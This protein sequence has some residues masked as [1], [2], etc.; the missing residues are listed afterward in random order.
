VH[1]RPDQN[2]DVGVLDTT[3]PT[4]SGRAGAP[5]DGPCRLSRV[6]GTMAITMGIGT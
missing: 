1:G 6:G 5:R 3:V 2:F 4:A